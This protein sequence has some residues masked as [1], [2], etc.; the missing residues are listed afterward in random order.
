[1]SKESEKT[2]IRRAF[3][4]AAHGYDQV[5]QLQREVGLQLLRHLDANPFTG[6]IVDLGCG[7]GFLTA[8]LLKKRPGQAITA[9]DLALP[10]LR[11]ARGK[12]DAETI[13]Y[14][15]ADAENLPFA[16]A[17]LDLVVSNLALQWCGALD[18]ALTDIYRAL[19]PGGTLAFTTFA[20]GTLEELKT[21]WAGVDQHH[22]VNQFHDAQ[23]LLL[24][25]QEAGFNGIRLHGRCYQP[26]Y[27]SVLD[28]LKELKQ[29]GARTVVAGRSPHLTG[30]Q[31]MQA[32]MAAYQQVCGAQITASFHVITLTAER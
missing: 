16:D 12:W 14:V 1:M 29:L 21:A 28:L 32:M 2:K 15:C 17:S 4:A 30:K 10:M 25:L 23:Q 19:K 20:D 9:L 26:Q 8:E 5:A 11:I 6:R 13:T 27:G 31:K 7:T 3:S 22:H 18:K 24:L